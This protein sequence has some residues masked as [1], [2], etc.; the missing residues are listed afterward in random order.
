MSDTR[1]FTLP[2]VR[3]HLADGS[4]FAVTITN[5]D[6]L[7]WDLTAPRR[8]WGKASEVPV[9][10]QTFVSWC[11]AKREKHTEMSWEAFQEALL[12]LEDVEEEPVVIR[13]TKTAATGEPS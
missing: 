1:E 4:S 5:G 6:R 9:L 12:G 3:C 11:A 13:P 2:R 10:A 7:Q 8:K